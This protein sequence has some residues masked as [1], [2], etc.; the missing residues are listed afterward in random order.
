ML[1]NEQ[2]ASERVIK[3]LL[4]VAICCAL[5]LNDA[6]HPHQK[7]QF[8]PEIFTSFEDAY[9]KLKKCKKRRGDRH[10]TSFNPFIR[11]IENWLEHGQDLDFSQCDFVHPDFQDLLAEFLA[12]KRIRK[13]SYQIHRDYLTQAGQQIQ[14]NISQLAGIGLTPVRTVSSSQRSRGDAAMPMP[15]Q[16]LFT[17]AALGRTQS[18][19]PAKS[20]KAPTME[21]V[22]RIMQEVAKRDLLSA[23]KYQAVIEALQVELDLS[24]DGTI[25]WLQYLKEKF[26]KMPQ[27]SLSEQFQFSSEQPIELEEYINFIAIEYRFFDLPAFIGTEAPI[28]F[29]KLKAILGRLIQSESNNTQLMAMTTCYEDLLKKLATKQLPQRLDKDYIPFERRFIMN[30]E[31]YTFAYSFFGR[32]IGKTRQFLAILSCCERKLNNFISRVEYYL[33]TGTD[34]LKA[35]FLGDLD[36]QEKPALTWLMALLEIPF[37]DTV[38]AHVNQD[39]LPK[40]FQTG[41]LVNLLSSYQ[42]IYKFL[43]LVKEYIEQIRTIR[44]E[45]KDKSRI[46]ELYAILK[47]ITAIFKSALLSILFNTGEREFWRGLFLEVKPER[48]MV[49]TTFCEQLLPTT[50]P[51][52][53]RE[54]SIHMASDYPGFETTKLSAWCSEFG[55]VKGHFANSAIK[56]FVEL[57]EI[58]KTYLPLLL[59]L[60]HH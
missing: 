3:S 43:Q 6:E 26:G 59:P 54:C 38:P 57:G 4:H 5:K 17:S 46:S 42:R 53:M 37:S 2:F 39:G 33:K 22:K 25:K 12:I 10:K 35:A 45:I 40:N 31:F 24:D 32:E 47:E 60:P 50:I 18:R 30:S 13:Q 36:E 56:T 11:A 21:D 44:T 48:L 55:D 19:V 23:D 9:A 58:Y 7:P 52:L 28:R 8:T 51:Q 27:I 49:A 16:P 15:T 34:G 29:T 1:F 41:R 14:T 20:L